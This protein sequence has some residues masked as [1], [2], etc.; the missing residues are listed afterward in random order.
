[1]EDEP[2]NYQVFRHSP[3]LRIVTSNIYRYEQG[4]VNSLLTSVEKEAVK[5]QLKLFLPIIEEMIHNLQ[6]DDD[7]MAPA[8]RRILN[9]YL[10]TYYNKM[11]KAHLPRREWKEYSLLLKEH[12][13][14]KIDV[15]AESSC[16]GKTIACLKNLSVTSYPAYL[17]V[18]FLLRVVFTNFIR[19]RII[20]SYS[21]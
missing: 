18:E 20:A 5:E 14:Y 6:D 19:P 9:S 21:R 15:S 7:K 1:M 4:N 8:T 12:S 3:R 10:R 16:M 13:V 11:L 2:F 17:M